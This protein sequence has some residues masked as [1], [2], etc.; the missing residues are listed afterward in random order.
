MSQLMSMC[1]LMS[2][3]PP[4]DGLVNGSILRR[5]G[6][7]HHGRESRDVGEAVRGEGPGGHEAAR[8]AQRR[9]LEEDHVGGEV[10]GLRR[11]ASHRDEP[12]GD[13]QPAQVRRLR[14]AQAVDRDERHRPDER[15]A[16]EG[17]RHRRQGRDAGAAQEERGD[18]RLPGARPGRHGARPLRRGP[19]GDAADD[20]RADGG[21][22]PVRPHRRARRQHQEDRQRL[23]ARG[24]R[25]LRPPRP[26]QRAARRAQREP[27]AP[28]RA[29]RCGGLRR[30]SPRRASRDTARDGPGAGYLPRRR[31]A[32]HP[33][34][35][36]GAVRLLPAALRPA[37]ADRGDLH[38]RS[39]VGRAL[40][41]RRRP[42]DR[43]VRDGVLRSA[44]LRDGGDL[45]RGTRG[46]PGRADQRR[47]RAPRSALH[48]PQGAD[49]AEAVPE[50]A[51]AD[52]VRARARARC[53]VGGHE[54]RARAHQP[55]GRGRDGAVRALSRGLAAQAGER[56]DAEAR[57]D[58]P[59]GGGGHR[60]RGRGHRPDELRHVVRQSHEALARLRLLADPLRARLRRGAPARPRRG[61]H[62][63]ARARG[64]G[65]P[66]RGQHLHLS[67]HPPDLRR[68]HRG[69]GGGLD[70]PLRERGASAPD[71][72]HAQV[73]GPLAMDRSLRD[74]V[75]VIALIGSGHMVSHFLQLT[76]PPLFPLLRDELGVSWVALG[77]ISSVFYAVSGLAQPVAGFFVDHFGARRVLLA[78][79]VLAAVAIASA[80]LAPSYWALLPLA[81]LAGLGN[82]VFHP[83]DYSMLNATV[84][85]RRIARAYSVHQISGN[86]GWV[87]APVLVG[88]VTHL[89]NWR[90]ALLAAGGA[91]L[92]ATLVIALQTRGLGAPMPPLPRAHGT[93]LRADLRMLMA[94][95]I[96]M[97]FGYF[98]LLTASTGGIQTFAVPALGMIYRAPLVLA[99]GAL[100]VYLF[101]NASGVLTGGFLADRAT[102]HDLVASGALPL[103]AISV[104]MAM[105][106]FSMGVTAP[107]RDMLV[108][109]ATPRG[110]SG[111]VFGFVYSGLDVGSLIAPPVYGWFLDRGEPRA[112]FVVIA[113]VM[114]V[115]I[116]TVVQVRRR[117]VSAQ[118]APAG[119]E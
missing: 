39:D 29:V 119:G 50:T 64:A 66:D 2:P 60:R 70:R 57:H 38:A 45:S 101:G 11:G 104:V 9:R 40:R 113:A 56:T 41:P 58:A 44:S 47:P 76:L 28:A 110:S 42:R 33:A 79:M 103:G 51:S 16:R 7:D 89:A 116:A 4:D 115:M 31:H 95:P 72:A 85:G 96:L 8:E 24:H 14:S 75:R 10:A 114:L 73:L 99:T 108:R 54:R 77:V 6:R 20:H 84:S 111:K 100:T 22:H 12:R 87:L 19:Q 3:A 62:R 36:P 83:A 91:A 25:S 46:D 81:G 49:G 112:M 21:R 69:P 13:R 18:G 53:R 109:A 74:D 1:T 30:L 17:V 92:L 93:G 80:G 55:S 48:V 105:T 94:V 32:A 88:S 5:Q 37:P 59:R 15:Q 117:V 27:P 107:S 106:G 61:R 98:V 86:I 63:R 34:H 67:R 78:G 23:S 90:I 35:P 97:A 65:A 43:A 52:L 102:R 68:R 71:R 82:S 26:P 118:P